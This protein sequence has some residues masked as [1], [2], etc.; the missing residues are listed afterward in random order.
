MATL[1]TGS[2]GHLGEALVRVLRAAGEDV[3]GL[4]VLPSPT[5]DLVASVGDR[6]A[7]RRAMAEVVAVVHTATLHKP[8]VATHDRQAFVD[9]NVSGTLVLLEEAAAAG[10]GRFVLTSTTSAFG[11]ALAPPPGAPAAWVT[12]QLAPV[13]RNVYGVTKVAAEDLCALVA[14]DT[15]L[16]C[17][18]LR[19]SRFFREGDDDDAVRATYAPENVQVNELLHRRVDL[20]DVVVLHRLA[21][22]AAPRLGLARYVVS[23]TSPFGPDDLQQLRTDAPGVVRRLFPD[24][25][26]VYARLGWRLF[27][28]VDRV[29]VNEAA[30]RDLGWAPRWD[31]RHALDEVA[32]GRPA[33]SEL[34][35]RIGAKGYHPTST[36]PYTVR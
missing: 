3:V 1:V 34:A 12:E 11:R 30:R 36:G 19:T 18:V 23:A 26:E 13:P 8:H 7:V 10:V 35:T 4:D 16:P 25:P 20:E 5:T 6:S 33:C 31:F 2:S 14:R 17:V 21:L 28:G 24:Q 27:P 9:T 32:A 22:E 15:G 29:Y